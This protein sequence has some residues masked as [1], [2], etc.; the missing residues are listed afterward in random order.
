MSSSSWYTDLSKF[1]HWFAKWLRDFPPLPNQNKVKFDHKIS[2]YFRCDVIR[3]MWKRL[4]VLTKGCMIFS[5]C[6]FGLSCQRLG[7]ECFW[8]WV[9][10]VDFHRKPP[11][12]VLQ[13]ALGDGWMCQGRRRAGWQ[14][15]A[16]VWPE[17]NWGDD[18]WR[19]WSTSSW[20]SPGPLL[21]PAWTPSRR[22]CGPWSGRGWW[23]PLR[24][25]FES[26]LKFLSKGKDEV[27][28][29]LMFGDSNWLCHLSN[30]VRM[31]SI[32]LVICWKCAIVIRV[33]LLQWYWFIV[34]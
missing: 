5:K 17:V 15:Q 18:Q 32:Q 6:W 11:E 9:H 13:E 31:P 26:F 28:N 29:I 20:A 21:G 30:K 16:A 1:L 23:M 8:Q 19:G 25:P 12:A 34:S 10:E 22:W 24:R 2:I 33:L 14:E 27:C 4:R 7:P 3:V